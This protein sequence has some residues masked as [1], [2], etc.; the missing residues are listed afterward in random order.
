M[1]IMQQVP[2][3]SVLIPTY[4][5]ARYLREAVDS[6]LRQNFRDLEVII[7]DDAS[8][9]GTEALLAEFAARDPRVRCQVHPANLGMVANWNWCLAQARGR[10]V[11][12]LFGDDMLATDDALARQV[13]ALE[14]T[15]AAVMAVSARTL[16]DRDSRRCGRWDDLAE[17]GAHSGTEVGRE[18]LLRMR[19]LIGEPS[20]VLFRREAAT[21]GFDP[22]YRQIVDLE[23]WLRL[24]RRGNLVYTRDPLC[25][26]RVHEAQATVVNSRL[27][28]GFSEWA[29]ALADHLP[30][31]LPPGFALD[32]RSRKN[33]F[34]VLHYAR[35]SADRVVASQEVVDRL[36]PLIGTRR[37]LWYTLRFRMARPLVNLR[38]SLEKRLFGTRSEWSFASGWRRT[39]WQGDETLP[40]GVV[41]AAGVATSVTQHRP[42]A[43]PRHGEPETGTTTLLVAVINHGHNQR[44]L[45][46]KSRFS[47]HCPVIAIDSGSRLLPEE[48]ACFDICLPNVYY[49]GC[50]RA[51]TRYALAHGYGHLWIWASD[52][53][54]HD[55]GAAVAHCRSAFAR[56]GAGVYAPSATYSFFRHMAPRPGFGLRRVT[57]TDG[58]CVAARI[59]LWERVCDDF[60]G[61][62]YGFGV[63]IQLG[64]YARLQKRD[65]LVDHRYRVCHPQGAGYS[66]RK[67]TEEW[68]AWR[69]RQPFA[70][71]LF[72]R[73]ARK[74]FSKT[75]LGMRLLL[76]LPW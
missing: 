10:Y 38:L 14:N 75:P 6:V 43:G 34:V 72:H 30:H 9:D 20:A 5:Y 63:E 33:L 36:G 15:P 13:E 3:L 26:F 47:R 24:L 57:F 68:Q 37:R 22:R 35:K 64:M 59:G 29:L 42:A 67:A 7:A 4:R 12:Y 25:C 45:W 28:L 65:V 51:A 32:E 61:C 21:T 62:Q 2:T 40:G 19:N 39:H 73:L 66:V 31:Y 50:V 49:A 53:D 46:L 27:G 11:R 54:C 8:N 76:A 71:S 55:L 17:E 52:V 60:D 74:R 41:P 56:T 16:I 70:T 23:L 58:F 48:R 44:A 1:R 18:C 69:E